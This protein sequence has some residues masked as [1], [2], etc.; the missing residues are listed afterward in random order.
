MSITEMK[1]A[2][3]NL[4]ASEV[5]EL[6]TWLTHYQNESR[7]DDANDVNTDRFNSLMSEAYASGDPSPLTKSDIDD[8]RRSVKERIAERVSQK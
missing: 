7:K 5:G 1:R 3:R 8:A 2:I 4:H 6:M